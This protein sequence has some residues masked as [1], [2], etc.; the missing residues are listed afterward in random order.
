MTTS[1]KLTVITGPMFSGKCHKKGTNILMFDGHIKK[2]EDITVSDQL[3]GDDSKPRAVLSINNGV[4]QLYKVM[5]S[6]GDPYVVNDQ[7]ILSL[8]CSYSRQKKGNMSKK[9]VKGTIIDIPIQDFMN[10]SKTFRSYYKGYRVGVD[11][12]SQNLPLDPYILGI[13]LGDGSTNDTTLTT[14]DTEIL[15][16]WTKCAETFGLTIHPRGPCSYHA[17]CDQVGGTNELLNVLKDIDV[18]YN[19]H[20]PH[21]YLSNSRANRLQLLAGLLDTDGY[22]DNEKHSYEIIQKIEL[23]ADQIVFLARSLGMV[24]YVHETVKSCTY[25]GEKREG[26]YHR[27]HISGSCLDEIPCRLAYKHAPLHKNRNDLLV[28]ITIQPDGEGEYYGFTLDGNGRYV[29]GDFT[30]THNSTELQRQV[31]RMELSGKKC[32]IIKHAKDNR[33]GKQD[34]CCTHDLRTMQAIAVSSLWDAKDKCADVDVVGVDEGQFFPEIVEFVDEFVEQRGKHVIVAALD[35]TYEGKPFGRI[36]ELLSR[37]EQFVKL[38]AVCRNCGGDAS[39]TVRH[40]D[41]IGQEGVIEVVGAAEIYEAVCRKCR[42]I[43]KK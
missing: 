2:V 17:S 26:T 30:V 34:E 19:K 39:F 27:I 10:E 37:S 3:M 4:G 42:A 43:M 14:T 18:R 22:W 13:W 29:M 28:G 33:Y 36:H 40:P 7:H 5:P 38:S 25:K 1:G 11:F 9:Y 41:F 6:F 31:K 35:G 15:N 20:I 8:K 24:S 23:L 16:E 32:I 21:I 12:P